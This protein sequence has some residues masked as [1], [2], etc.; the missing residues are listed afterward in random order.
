M[1]GWVQ[2]EETAAPQPLYGVGGWLWAVF[3]GFVLCI[4]GSAVRLG[5]LV[6]GLLSDDE[7]LPLA[8]AVL[9]FMPVADLAFAVSFSAALVLGLRPG[10]RSF[11]ETATIACGL[12]IVYVI[13]YVF[14]FRHLTGTAAFELG[15]PQTWLH[16]IV[17]VA[18]CAAA[19]PY[20]QLSRRVRLTYLQ[21]VERQP[22]D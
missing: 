1:A 14:A 5:L 21:S 15:S 11:P 22:V 4:L 8:D 20:L 9:T 10:R 17:P 18:F 3:A 19:I 7:G 6:A 2:S 13:P 16:Y 12:Y